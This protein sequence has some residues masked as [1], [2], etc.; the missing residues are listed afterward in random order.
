MGAPS[1]GNQPQQPQPQPRLV[2]LSIS[3]TS[4]QTVRLAFTIPSQLED[5]APIIIAGSPAASPVPLPSEQRIVRL[6]VMAGAGG[7][8]QVAITG[9]ADADSA[10]PCSAAPLSPAPQDDN[11]DGSVQ[12]LL[13]APGPA[14][15]PPPPVGCDAYEPAAPDAVAT[16]T[17]ATP[18]AAAKAGKGKGKSKAGRKARALLARFKAAFKEFDDKLTAAN[19]KLVQRAA[20]IKA[21][22]ASRRATA[23]EAAATAAAA[24]P[25]PCR[26]PGSLRA[27]A[28]RMLAR[29]GSAKK[30]NAQL[31]AT[32][33]GA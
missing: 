27:M 15:P 30:M 31:T 17:L 12:L 23:E 5:A 13:A 29:L 6:A 18:G 16:F 32:A 10:A 2:R 8:V 24:K 4:E 7:A 26:S 28:S 33:N 11:A 21:A 19:H 14:G 20:A 1:T 25:A 9:A 22:A 3:T